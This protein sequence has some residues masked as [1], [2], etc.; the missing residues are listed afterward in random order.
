MTGGATPVYAAPETFEGIITPYCDQYSLAIVYQELLTG[1][2]PFSATNLQQLIAQ[3]LQ[4]APDLS[5]LPPNDRIAVAKALAKRPEDRHASCRDFVRGLIAGANATETPSPTAATHPTAPIL[6]PPGEITFQTAPW[7]GGETPTTQVLLRPEDASTSGDLAPSRAAPPEELGDG[8]LFP[9]IVIGLGR[10]GVEVLRGIKR[11]IHE[12]VGGSERVPNIR[13]FGIDTDPDTLQ[14]A[15]EN[16]D[17]SPLHPD[18]VFSARLNRPAHYLKPRRNG[19]SLLEGWFDP[20]TLYRIKAANPTTQG[21]RTL[22]R[23]AFCDH[24]RSIEQKLRTELEAV[25][26]PST[27]DHAEMQSQLTRRSNRPRVYIVA[28]LAGATGGGM[29]IDVAYCAKAMLRSLGYA[30]PDVRGLLLLPPHAGPLAKPQAL[31]NTY[32]ALTELHHF[33]MPGVT[34][35]M[36]IDDRDVTLV[37]SG[38]PFSQFFLLPLQNHRSSTAEAPGIGQVAEFVW[39]DL[40]TPFGRAVDASREEAMAMPGVTPDPETIAGHTFG[41]YTVTWPRRQLADRVARWLCCR[42][43]EVWCLTENK[44]IQPTIDQ[45]VREQWEAQQFTPE[46]LLAQCQKAC[47]SAIGMSTEKYL[48]DLAEPLLPRSRWSRAAYDSAVAFQALTSAVQW[49]GHPV[50]NGMQRPTGRLESI[51]QHLADAVFQDWSHR[52]RQI[53]LCLIEQPGFRLFGAETA[54]ASLQTLCRQAIAHFEPHLH[55]RS[56]RAEAAYQAAERLL[57]EDVRRKRGAE[58]ADYLTQF[59]L[60]R[61]QLLL[62]RTVSQVFVRLNDYLADILKEVNLCRRR[63]LEMKDHL[64]PMGGSTHTTGLLLPEGCHNLQEAVEMLRDSI[65]PQAHA[66]LDREMQAIIEQRCQSLLQACLTATEVRSDLESALLQL[67]RKRIY[68][69]LGG[70]DVAEL[71]LKRYGEPERAQKAVARAFAYAEPSLDVPD[72]PNDFAELLAVPL[73]ES[74][75]RFLQL[76]AENLPDANPTIAESPDDIVFYRERVTVPLKHL[77]HLGSAGHEAY[78]QFLEQQTPIHSR[79]D[80]RHWYAAG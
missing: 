34:Y 59:S 3:H 44:S 16:P 70:V 57:A 20:Q 33:S 27:L 14:E 45:W 54:A 11:A 63:L 47:D 1:K 72:A 24:Y 5:P 6:V 61:F 15:L 67:V 10:T 58:I 73:R 36:N 2:R 79:H 77:P 7:T 12:H 8:V 78:F 68:D 22:G 30:E 37:D 4:A 64:A 62:G 43:L 40:L 28:N 51:L 26:H 29:F 13:L 23:L 39:R 18:E 66:E 80:I 50:E 42:V 32:A 71:F 46:L 56:Q 48:S 60:A 31:A 74:C 52:L 75:H 55:E 21:I 49:L 53:A 41:L 38:P 17:G 69:Q 65:E 35:T 9:A 19:R 76:V 25:T